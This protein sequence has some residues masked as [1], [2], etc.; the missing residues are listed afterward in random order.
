MLLE[1]Q[2]CSWNRGLQ[3]R[4]ER[5]GLH[6]AFQWKEQDRKKVEVQGKLHATPGKKLLRKKIVH[7]DYRCF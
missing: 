5:R 6:G 4:G 2:V 7:N 1:G 3:G